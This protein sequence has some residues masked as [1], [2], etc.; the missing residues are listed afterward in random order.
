M[1]IAYIEDAFNTDQAL[2]MEQSRSTEHAALA[3]AEETG[4]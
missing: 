4:S 1:N 3:D 2:N